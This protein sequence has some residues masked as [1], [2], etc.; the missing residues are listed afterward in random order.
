MSNRKRIIKYRTLLEILDN[1]ARTKNT[2]KFKNF[3]SYLDD[4]ALKFLAECV[5]NILSPRTFKVLKT[6]NQD[7][8]LKSS[9]PH[10]RAIKTFIKAET[11]GRKRKGIVQKG[12]AWFLPLITSLIPLFAG[13]FKKQ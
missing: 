5:R 11:E 12:G 7:S 3:I 8:L 4:D 13:L 2:S 10:K 9:A 1:L 6:E